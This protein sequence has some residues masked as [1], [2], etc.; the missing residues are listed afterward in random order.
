MQKR[1]EY[2]SSKCQTLVMFVHVLVIFCFVVVSYVYVSYIVCFFVLF[3][4][5]FFIA[6]LLTNYKKPLVIALFVFWKMG[7]VVVTLVTPKLM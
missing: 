3:I 1:Y 2:R 4:L 6:K 5:F 7:K